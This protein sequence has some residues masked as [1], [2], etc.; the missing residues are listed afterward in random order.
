MAEEEEKD[1][2][3]HVH[4]MGGL[5]GKGVPIRTARCG[6][7]AKWQLVHQ[8]LSFLLL[9]FVVTMSGSLSLPFNSQPLIITVCPVF[10]FCVESSL[11]G[12]KK[13]AKKISWP[14]RKLHNFLLL[15]LN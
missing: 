1:V 14:E 12:S 13:K 2:H 15:L 11:L 7:R 10:F 5:K 3:V 4:V 6:L 9:L 8:C